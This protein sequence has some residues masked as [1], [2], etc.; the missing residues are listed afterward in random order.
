MN[1]LK[2]IEGDAK[3]IIRIMKRTNVVGK[4]RMLR[5]NCSAEP[6]GLKRKKTSVCRLFV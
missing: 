1:V 2:S 4:A 3:K 5:R 6:V